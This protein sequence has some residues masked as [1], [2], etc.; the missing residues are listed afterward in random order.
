MYLVS[1]LKETS[2]SLKFIIHIYR[3]PTGQFLELI[4]ENELQFR[5]N[6]LFAEIEIVLIAAASACEPSNNDHGLAT[7]VMHGATTS[8]VDSNRIRYLLPPLI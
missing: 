2:D 4:A 6:D 7:S 8:I 1:D 5:L 3:Y